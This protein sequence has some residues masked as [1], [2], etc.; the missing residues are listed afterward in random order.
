VPSPEL[1]LVGAV[2]KLL[3]EGLG[4]EATLAAV[5]ETLRRGLPAEGVTVWMREH[6]TPAFRSVQAPPAPDGPAPV[7]SLDSV[8][9]RPDWRRYV[10]EHEGVRLG[11]LEARLGAG[12]SDPEA[13]P[14]VADFLAPYLAAA[15]LSVDLAGEVAAQSREI[16]EHRRFTSLIVDSL[17]VGLYV[18]DRDYRI[19]SWNRK[20]ETGTQGLRRDDVVGRPVFDVLTRQPP[21]QLRAEFDRVFETGEIQQTE[22]EVTAGGDTRR[23]R[24]SKIP[25]RLDGDEITHVITIG[26]DVTDYH[27]AQRQ[28]LQS[29]KL[30]AIGQLAAGVMHEINNPL[31]TISACVAAIEGRLSAGPETAQAEEYLQTIDREV[32]RCSRI[33]DGLLDFSRPKAG[34]RR[35][36]SL[37]GLVDETLFLLKHH[38][39]FKQLHVVRALA[40]G[41][42]DTLGS[43]EQLTQVLMALMLNALDAMEQGGQLTVRTGLSPARADEVVVEVEDTGIGIPPDDQGKIFEPFYTTKP[44]GRG[45]GLG[46]SIC[47]GIVADH[48]GRIEV[49]SALGRGATFRV[50]LPV[51]A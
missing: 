4:T 27:H 22:Q 13:L 2:A 19:Q 30:A 25:M 24:L 37:N 45:T 12:D 35:R 15:E 6:G 29:E 33:V 26:E 11:L 7:R 43:P 16:E 21:A 34:P 14:I 32:D 40:P 46:L 49:D 5:A 51:A 36:V 10:L 31:A 20:R 48:R 1:A 38:R 8:P 18:V 47:Y 39:R 50:F 41:L 17:P 3:N 44:P 42:P 23:F 9:P 28:I